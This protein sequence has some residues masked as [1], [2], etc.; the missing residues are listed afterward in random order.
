MGGTE[1]E[2]LSPQC[3]DD[4]NYSSRLDM[5]L[6]V[7]SSCWTTPVNFYFMCHSSYEEYSALILLQ[8]QVI[9]DN[10]ILEIIFLLK[11]EV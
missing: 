4:H 6:E 8:N 7:A 11:I 5:A 1:R 10:L 3:N 9:F 2:N